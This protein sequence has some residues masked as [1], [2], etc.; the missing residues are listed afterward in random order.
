[1]SRRFIILLGIAIASLAFPC[2]GQSSASFRLNRTAISNGGGRQTSGSFILVQS[3]IGVF[4]G[5]QSESSSFKL[6]GGALTTKV[7]DQLPGQSNLPYSF[8]LSQN[9]PN[10]FN[11]ETMIEYGLPKEVEVTIKIFNVY[12][13][14]IRTLVQGYQ[15]PGHHRIQWDG[16]DD[17]GHHAASGLYHVRIVAEGFMEVRK[18]IL[19]R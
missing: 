17:E 10:P 7:E 11:P 2:F 12:G 18:M 1:M 14:E 16:K 9:Y 5:G 6:N 4:V 19:V 3:A 8:F 13:Q 15:Q